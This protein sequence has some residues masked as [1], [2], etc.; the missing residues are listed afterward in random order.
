M[1]DE[2]APL[3]C[4]LNELIL[5][6]FKNCFDDSLLRVN[7]ELNTGMCVHDIVTGLSNFEKDLLKCLQVTF[8]ML[9]DC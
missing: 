5:E 7:M 9:R 3:T 4:A 6:G 2:A 8:K 1:P